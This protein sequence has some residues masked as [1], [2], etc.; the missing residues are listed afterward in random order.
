[1]NARA[2]SMMREHKAT[3]CRIC[4]PLC[5]MVATVEDGRLALVTARQGPPAVSGFRLPEGH[6]VRR[7]GQR[8]RPCDDAAAPGRSEA[9]RGSVQRGRRLVRA[10]VLG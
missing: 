4:E 10:G 5:G 9:A 3:F 1:M 7:G 6:R 8:P 2:K